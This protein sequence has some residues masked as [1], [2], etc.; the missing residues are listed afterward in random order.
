MRLVSRVIRQRAC[1]GVVVAVGLGMTAPSSATNLPAGF[2]EELILDNL[3]GPMTMAWGPN[4]ELWLGG[5]QGHI[6]VLRG[7]DLVQ[8]AQ[9]ATSDF[10][11]RGVHG[12]AVD[13]DYDANRHVWIYYSTDGPPFRNRLAR[14]Q[15]VGDQL[16]DETLILETPELVE[17]VHNGGCI[18]FAPD[19]TIFLTTGDDNQRS[20]PQDPHD[21]RGKILHINRD[22]SP[23]EGNPYLDGGGDPRVWAIGFRNPWR[24]SLQPESDNLFIGDVGASRYEELN[25]GVPG[26]NF[27]WREV[28]G[29]E[30]PGILGM[31]YPIYAYPHTSEL[32]HA[33]IAGEHASTLN[34][35]PEYEG[36]FFFGDAVTKEISRMVLDELNQPISVGVFASDTP[37]GP[38]DIRFG[39]D[40]ALYYLS[41]NGGKLSRIAFA[42]G[43]NRQPV[44]MATA[45]PDNG[46]SPLTVTLDASSSFDPDGNPLAFAWD[47]GDGTMGSGPVATKQYA[48][49]S[50]SASLTVTDSE[51]GESIVRGIR[52]VSGNTRPHAI[53]TFPPH[54]QRYSEGELIHFAGTA[55]DPE[56]GLLPC[57][58]FVWSVIFHHKGHTHPFLGPLQGSC[59]GVFVVNSHGEEQTFYE[60][61]LTVQDEGMPLGD[62]G[63]LTGT[64]S[65]SL[66]PRD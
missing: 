52:V 46:A 31:V 48:P 4:G 9:L 11:E 8:V 54:G 14:F 45:T 28:E 39:P 38:V 33:I 49:G 30:P 15:N 65:I 43:S 24:F 35:P 40:G 56:E 53:V 57:R 42:G 10:G 13:P 66:F 5:Q 16:V 32:G 64:Q 22:G 19:E 51:G 41:F 61:S 34:F 50:Y 44:A 36:D 21:I 37:E 17:D 27:G 62:E 18:R 3:P 25:I 58:Q 23:A 2:V 12:I 63:Q 20:V 1:A 59:S 6:W 29:P 47:F 26:G 55:L 60:I 7:N